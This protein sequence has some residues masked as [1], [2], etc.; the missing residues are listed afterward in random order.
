[1]G[2]WV[3]RDLNKADSPF[4]LLLW[5]EYGQGTMTIRKIKE[6]KNMV[7][8]IDRELKRISQLPEIEKKK[9]LA[10]LPYTTE[11]KIK[12]E[13]DISG[14]LPYEIRDWVSSVMIDWVEHGRDKQVERDD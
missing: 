1:L 4:K 13:L 11:L 3:V 7:V 2:E 10:N 9:E 12:K 5:Y 6:E 14:S 8:G